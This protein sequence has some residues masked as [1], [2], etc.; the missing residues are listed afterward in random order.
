MRTDE[1]QFYKINIAPTTIIII[2][3]VIIGIGVFLPDIIYYFIHR[4]KESA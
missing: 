2:M 1:V 3:L 4:K